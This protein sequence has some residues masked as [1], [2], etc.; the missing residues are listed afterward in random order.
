MALEP[1]PSIRP[2]PI[3]EECAAPAEVR[4]LVGA[5]I[6]GQAHALDA[7]LPYVELALAGLAPAG[8]PA[9]VFLLLG[10]TGTGKTRTAEALARAIHGSE[11]NLLRVDCGEFQLDHEVAKLIGAPPGY[12]GHRET[13]PL[14]SQQKLNAVTS[15]QSALSIVLFDE[16]EKAAPSFTRILLGV[17]DRA[18]LKLGDNSTVNFEN[19]L[20]FLTSNLGA[21]GIQSELE[22]GYGFSARAD[23]PRAGRE[24]HTR[25]ERIATAAVRKR[26]S[27]EFVNRLDEIVTYNPLDRAA[28]E[29]ILRQQLEQLQEHVEARLG[30]AAF[31]VEVGES[32]RRFLLRAG[33]SDEYGARE[34]KRAI[35][36]HLMQ[37]LGAMVLQRRV[38][39]G[40]RVRVEFNAKRSRLEFDPLRRAA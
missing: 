32:A 15:E 39:P 18:T 38:E 14:L 10:P 1:L 19:S 16:I 13:V 20:I 37:P 30:L 5:A 27:P 28:L 2:R 7:I 29:A 24:S 25:L 17:L 9:G 6:Y 8:R 12:L 40:A 11:R 35:H 33:T 34:L 31:E 4:R 36:R 21:R 23:A 22:G 3:R 26:F